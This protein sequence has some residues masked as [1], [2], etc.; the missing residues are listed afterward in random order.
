MKEK[1]NAVRNEHVKRWHSYKQNKN[2]TDSCACD[3]NFQPTNKENTEGGSRKSQSQFSQS[4]LKKAAI[5]TAA[6]RI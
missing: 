1:R 6:F 3:A 2:L 4:H 5:S